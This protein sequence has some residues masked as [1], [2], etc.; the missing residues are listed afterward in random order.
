MKAYTFQSSTR[1]CSLFR[2]KIR[3]GIS[4]FHAILNVIHVLT[5][6]N[7]SRSN[8]NKCTKC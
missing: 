6:I 8:A 1:N 2:T 4:T 3:V 7:N 5:S